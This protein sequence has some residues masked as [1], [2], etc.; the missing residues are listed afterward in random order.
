[1]AIPGRQDLK[2]QSSFFKGKKN[3]LHCVIALEKLLVSHLFFHLSPLPRWGSS[4]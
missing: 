3:A 4:P 1:M 2:W